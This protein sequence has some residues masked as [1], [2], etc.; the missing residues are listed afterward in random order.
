MANHH[1]HDEHPQDL[2]L[3]EEMNYETRDFDV[4][5][6]PKGTVWFFGVT[7]GFFILAFI[8]L[9]FMGPD[10][11]PWFREGK[12]QTANQP[13]VRRRMPEAPAPLLQSNITASKDTVDLRKKEADKLATYGWA[14]KE[15]T[16]AKIPVEEAMNMVASQG[17][18]PR[19]A[20]TTPAP[21]ATAENR[22]ANT[23]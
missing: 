18:L 5:Q 22:P 16:A 10:F 4:D 1:D 20:P 17:K 8:S 6:A 11:I 15:K 14:N 21:T 3:L 7:T 9:I 23:R 2:N 12:F 19:W 13:D